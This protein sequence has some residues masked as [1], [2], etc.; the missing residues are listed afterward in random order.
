[1]R[2]VSFAKMDSAEPTKK[3]VSVTISPNRFNSQR[4]LRCTVEECWR[5][6]KCSSS[7]CSWHGIE[8]ISSHEIRDEF[9]TGYW[10]ELS[11]THKC[12]KGSFF[13]SA[14]YSFRSYKKEEE[15][16]SERKQ[17]LL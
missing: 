11:F 13:I 3:K 12:T 8:M 17:V 5:N 10:K 7:I 1:L 16:T 4:T 6:E 9:A 2:E 15:D 14:A